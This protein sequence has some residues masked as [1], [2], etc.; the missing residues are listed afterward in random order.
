MSDVAGS[1]LECA[2]HI[3]ASSKKESQR[4]A[5]FEPLLVNYFLPRLW[6]STFLLPHTKQTHV[7]TA[8]LLTKN[9]Y[10]KEFNSSSIRI[11]DKAETIFRQYSTQQCIQYKSC[12]LNTTRNT[13]NTYSMNKNISFKNQ[14][15]LCSSTKKDKPKPSIIETWSFYFKDAMK[16]HLEQN[17]V[18]W[19]RTYNC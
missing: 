2:P 9:P 17:T 3:C 6:T 12:T 5:K 16:L 19:A 1:Y 18:N 14:E 15:Q 8:A 13:R 11:I 10:S 4:I 7:F